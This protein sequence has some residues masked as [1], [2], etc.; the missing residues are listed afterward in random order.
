[1]RG[2]QLPVPPQVMTS[3]V[4]LELRSKVL[5]PIWAAT[6]EEKVIDVGQKSQYC[7]LD[8]TAD[9]LPR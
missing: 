2:I 7:R 5:D 6:G 4:S 3:E 8:L 1:M 9:L